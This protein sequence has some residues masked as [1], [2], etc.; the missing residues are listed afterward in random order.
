LLELEIENSEQQSFF[1]LDLPNTLT[2]LHFLKCDKL[3]HMPKK[4]PINLRSLKVVA[5]T[6]LLTMPS[7]PHSLNNFVFEI[8]DGMSSDYPSVTSVMLPVLPPN[9]E[10]FKLVNY[11]VHFPDLPESLKHLIVDRQR[12]MKYLKDLPEGL[13][14]L[15]LLNSFIGAF[16]NLPS[17]LQVFELHKCIYLKF[18]YTSIPSTLRKLS[19]SSDCEEVFL[20]AEIPKECTVY[21][22][23]Q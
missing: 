14:R 11:N 19:F 21:H 5:N 16:P 3:T 2:S 6:R 17:N 12:D 15:S 10:K 8:Y 7:L 13:I 4:L 23:T 1:E 18:R 22:S 20:N 9:L